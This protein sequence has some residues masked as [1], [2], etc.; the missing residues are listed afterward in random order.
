MIAD[1]YIDIGNYDVELG[2]DDLV[3]PDNDDLGQE[4]WEIMAGEYR[5]TLED[6]CG[7]LRRRLSDSEQGIAIVCWKISTS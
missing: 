3:E 4:Q 1:P 5:E 6:C 2:N 7:E